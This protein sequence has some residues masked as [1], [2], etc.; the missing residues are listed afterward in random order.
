[1]RTTKKKFSTN[2]VLKKLAPLLAILGVSLLFFAANFKS[3][4]LVLRG[5]TGYP[6]DPSLALEKYSYAWFGFIFNGQP[7]GHAYNFAFPLL[8]IIYVLN[9][10]FNPQISQFILLTS[11]LFLSGFL[12]YLFFSKV[13]KG[14]PLN[15]L[16]GA[17]FYMLN[18]IIITEWYVPNPWFLLAYV[19][20]P[21]TAIACYYVVTNFVL[22]LSLLA[23]SYIFIASSFANTP[24]I[25]ISFL[26]GLFIIFY[27]CV[28][29]NIRFKKQIFYAVSYALVF[30]LANCWW[31]G[32]L[33][34]YR[35]EGY[36]VLTTGVGVSSWAEGASRHAHFIYVLLSQFTPTI[37]GKSFEYTRFITSTGFSLIYIIFPV[38][39]FSYFFHKKREYHTILLLIALVITFFFVKGTQPPFGS[40]YLWLLKNV[41][42]FAVFKTPSEKFGVL[43]IFL[44]SLALST[45]N[46]QSRL[47]VFA[48]IILLAFSYPVY[49]GKL[50]PDIEISKGTILQA[51]QKVDKSYFRVSDLINE[52]KREGRVLLLPGTAN[53]MD[54]YKSSRFR[55]LS[56]IS[57]L[58]NKPLIKGYSLRRDNLG[59]L[60]KNISNEEKFISLLKLYNINWIVL[61]KDID[62]N[63]YGFTHKE[64][65]KTIES[66]LNSY[67][68]LKRVISV[69]PLLLFRFNRVGGADASINE[70]PLPRI[71]TPP[72]VKVYVPS[73][74][75]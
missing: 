32:L 53:Y 60:I 22:G 59:V 50:F 6:L 4:H 72:I 46:S 38:L 36:Q 27:L 51:Y 26:S 37:A 21:F 12:P 71:Y 52:D 62:I 44:T 29:N 24:F 15:N 14:Q 18:P 67:K 35:A 25:G 39:I 65:I 17:L 34:E 28:R 73:T 66:R 43:L 45:I 13:N 68:D 40:I 42:Y 69:G 49:S 75:K 47:I 70:N 63:A 74:T 58:I 20:I 41:P 30:F 11:L 33:L 31:L 57:S 5:D 7:A 3:G 8:V 54:T 23:L 2:E 16:L 48:I 9:Q 10:F 19:S 1:M 56:W 64:S 55:G 61:N